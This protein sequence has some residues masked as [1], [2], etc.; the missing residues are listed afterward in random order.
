MASNRRQPRQQAAASSQPFGSQSS[1]TAPPKSIIQ[2]DAI[3]SLW[4]AYVKLQT[5][6]WGADAT[7]GSTIPTPQVAIDRLTEAHLSGRVAAI[8]ATPKDVTIGGCYLRYSDENSNPR[9]L[10]Q[11]LRNVLVRAAKDK[12]WI[13]WERVCADSA[14]S[15]RTANRPGFILSTQVVAD[16]SDPMKV[17]Y[18][19]DL[20]RLSR[21]TIDSLQFGKLI[22]AGGKK[23][24]GVSDGHDSS[25]P[26][27]HITHPLSAVQHAMFSRQLTEK[28][29]RGERD[30]FYREQN[31][32]AIPTGYKLNF[33]LTDEGQP[34]IN[35]KGKPVS[36]VVVDQEAAEVIVKIFTLYSNEKMSPQRI[37]KTLNGEKA[38]GRNSWNES[39][40]KQILRNERY[41]GQ[42]YFNRKKNVLDPVTGKRKV[43]PRPKSEWYHREDSAMRIISD[44]LWERTQ[45]RLKEVSRSFGQRKTDSDSRQSIYP[46]RLFDLYCEHCQLPLQLLRGGKPDDA[47]L[48]CPSGDQHSYDCPLRSSKMLRII[49]EC[50]LGYLKV[51]LLDDES[52]QE[53]VTLANQFVFE[54]SSKPPVDVEA[55]DRKISSLKSRIKRTID[56]ATNVD[57]ETA[58]NQLMNKVKQLEKELLALQDQLNAGAKMSEA[59]TPIPAEF[60]T[61]ALAELRSLLNDD[62]ASAHHILSKAVDKVYITQGEKRGR[63]TV[64][65]AKLQIDLVPVL[66]EIARRTS[67]PTI[68]TLEFLRLSTWRTIN[69]I[70]AEIHEIKHVHRIAAEVAELLA[71]GCVIKTISDYLG[72]DHRTVTE[73]RNFAS[74]HP[75][76]A[77]RLASSKLRA[78]AEDALFKQYA[79]QVGELHDA[80][81]SIKS[82]AEQLGISQS[83]VTAAYDYY[84]ASAITLAVQ[85]GKRAA[86]YDDDGTLISAETQEQIR[87]RLR[88]GEPH[89][90]IAREVGVDRD[91][92]R[93][94]KR[95]MEEAQQDAA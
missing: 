47:S 49:D 26:M 71:K 28:V 59:L 5:E 1:V 16:A 37:A 76:A 61:S 89:R 79:Q 82:I 73:A 11:Q 39:S 80:G 9:S 43:V 41:I 19:D 44:E 18:V 74:E 67:S 83:T 14:I 81:H 32:G 42:I 8:N 27:A 77:R 87:T 94:Q 23:L 91:T 22:E 40:V 46:T 85:K 86:R 70:D 58:S 24:V 50:L 48:H 51:Q 29:I 66:V 68:H 25:N 36:E 57:S 52:T 15:G 12:V 55:M 72:V 7:V 30:A 53:V 60:V 34:Q 6:L 38:L 78:R 62:A 84:D 45:Q 33:L 75:D 92:V 4:T 65:L 17:F 10:D 2:P 56:Q 3:H 90:R 88:N 20:S 63:S 21:D 31:V 93:R 35:H 69:P 54:Q 13:P 64:W 95:L